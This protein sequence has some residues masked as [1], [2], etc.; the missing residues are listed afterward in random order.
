VIIALMR[1]VPIGL[2]PFILIIEGTV[3]FQVAHR[4]FDVL[5]DNSRN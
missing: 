1:F 2:W 5:P 3:G 4:L